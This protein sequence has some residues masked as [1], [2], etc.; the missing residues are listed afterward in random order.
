[1]NKKLIIG[2]FGVLL[3][4][5]ALVLVFNGVNNNDTNNDSV[6]NNNT[7]NGVK[8]KNYTEGISEIKNS[9]KSLFLF[10]TAQ[11]CKPCKDF[12]NDAST[13]QNLINKVNEYIPVMVE[14]EKDPELIKKYNINLF[15]T[16]IILDSNEKEISRFSGYGTAEQF[17]KDLNKIKL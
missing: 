16:F 11:G 15:P 17:I 2:I 13:N 4:C 12:K 14:L 7:D 3:I 10:F 5:I 8:W 9:N 1:M 6:I